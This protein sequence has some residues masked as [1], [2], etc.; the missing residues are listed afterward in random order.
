[1]VEI[2]NSWILDARYMPI[3]TMMK[4]IRK[5]IINML[6][7]KGPLCEKWMNCFSLACSE[8]FHINKGLVVR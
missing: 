5:K 1:M 3:R 2:F 6:S 8:N 7:M 4:F